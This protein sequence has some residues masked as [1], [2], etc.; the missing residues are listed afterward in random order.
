MR[1]DWCI[2]RTVWLV[3]GV[4]A[5]RFS[6]QVD[7][8]SA[9]DFWERYH[10][11]RLKISTNSI[12][13]QSTSNQL[14]V[15]DVGIAGMWWMMLLT[16]WDVLVAA[17]GKCNLYIGA[18]LMLSSVGDTAEQL[19]ANFCTWRGY[20]SGLPPHKAK[21]YQVTSNFRA[22][23]PLLLMTDYEWGFNNVN[24]Q[25]V[26]SS[27][28]AYQTEPVPLT[29]IPPIQCCGKK[30]YDT[31]DNAPTNWECSSWSKVKIAPFNFKMWKRLRYLLSTHQSANS[32]E[33]GK[34]INNSP[35]EH[36][37]IPLPLPGMPTYL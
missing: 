6:F 18:L 4:L 37:M 5:S 19:D 29:V 36:W 1:A 23:P 30:T 10:C 20:K 21:N 11:S 33:P 24:S 13:R 2:S 26:L 31:F 16:K 32:K 28:A 35:L 8:S 7:L 12:N 27:I 14:R 17:S 3:A 9:L 34:A 15:V 22:P 25:Q